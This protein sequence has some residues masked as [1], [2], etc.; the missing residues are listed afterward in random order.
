MDFTLW[1]NATFY[2]QE[3]SPIHKPEPRGGHSIS[4][5]ALSCFVDASWV[6]SHSRWLLKSSSSIEPTHSVLEAEATTLFEAILQVKRL[7]YRHITFDG[8]S[9]AL[10]LHLEKSSKLERSLFGP[11]EIQTYL[12][13]LRAIAPVDYSFKLCW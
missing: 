1:K 10:Y 6:D 3:Q 13:D 8:D 4:N 11:V 9:S 2:Y 7:N 12:D 5:S